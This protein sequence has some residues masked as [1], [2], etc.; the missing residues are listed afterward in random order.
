MEGQRC[1]GA[2]VLVGVKTQNQVARRVWGRACNS[3]ARKVMEG[4]VGKGQQCHTCMHAC[5][6]ASGVSDS[7][8]PWTV[9]LQAPLS[10]GFSRQEYWSGLPCPP[11]GDLSNADVKPESPVWLTR[12]L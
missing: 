7:A 5:S 12:V 1:D 8:T 6:I 4:E 11:P 10:M 9:A 3:C 2:G